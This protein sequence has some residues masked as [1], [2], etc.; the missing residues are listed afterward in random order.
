MRNMRRSLS[1]TRTAP[2]SSARPRP[3]ETDITTRHACMRAEW[4]SKRSKRPGGPSASRRSRP[5]LA[6]RGRTS[7]WRR[8]STSPT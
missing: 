5:R 7:L 2:C 8:R 1:T 4:S 3:G 6:L